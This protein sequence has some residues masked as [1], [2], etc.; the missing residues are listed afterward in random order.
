[1]LARGFASVMHERMER[2]LFAPGFCKRLG[3]KCNAAERRKFDARDRGGFVSSRIGNFRITGP[4]FVRAWEE[5]IAI[6][7]EVGWNDW[8]ESKS[9]PFMTFHECRVSGIDFEDAERNHADMNLVEAHFTAQFREMVA[10]MKAKGKRF[11]GKVIQA[12]IGDLRKAKRKP[13]RKKST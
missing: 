12:D 4:I 2:R 7:W 10:G 11:R 1:M 13:R 6:V 8:N 5:T 3:L 9:K